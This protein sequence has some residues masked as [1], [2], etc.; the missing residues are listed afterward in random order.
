MFLKAIQNQTQNEQYLYTAQ[1]QAQPQNTTEYQTPKQYAFE[2]QTKARS[3]ETSPYNTAPGQHHA[4]KWLQS[5][6]NNP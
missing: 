5:G 2:D 6:L 1:N 4:R 3:E